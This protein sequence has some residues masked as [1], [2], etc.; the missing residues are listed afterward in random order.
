[1]SIWTISYPA[2][3]FWKIGLEKVTRLLLHMVTSSRQVRRRRRMRRMKEEMTVE[4]V[5]IDGLEAGGLLQLAVAPPKYKKNSKEHIEHARNARLQAL[6]KKKEDKA[7]AGEKDAKTALH[8]VCS[9]MPGAAQI[10]GQQ[11][12]VAIGRKKHIVAED[13]KVLV[14][15][16]FLKATIA[17]NAGIKLRR[18]ICTGA[19]FIEARQQRALT[20]LIDRLIRLSLQAVSTRCTPM[21][22][23]TH[24]HLWDEVQVAF[25]EGS[26]AS[27]GSRRQRKPHKQWC[28]DRLYL[29]VWPTCKRNVLCRSTSFG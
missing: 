13:C 18:L 5:Q 10:I 12:G 4:G 28:S 11:K 22:H 23:I 26:M 16:L 6:A 20:L 1:M 25:Q 8:A 15:A 21:V 9:L 29:S 17:V 19:K 24:C 27:F 2:W 14:R 3:A 7:R